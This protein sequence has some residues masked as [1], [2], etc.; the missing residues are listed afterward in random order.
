LLALV[1]GAIFLVCVELVASLFVTAIVDFLIRLVT[2]DT[3]FAGDVFLSAE[4]GRRR[5]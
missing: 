3:G 5:I 2:L 1:G 4:R